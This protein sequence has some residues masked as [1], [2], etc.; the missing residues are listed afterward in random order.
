MDAD[1]GGF[2]AGASAGSEHGDV[3]AGRTA[4]TVCAPFFCY[5]AAPMALVNSTISMRLPPATTTM[6]RIVLLVNV[7]AHKIASDWG[8]PQLPK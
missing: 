6:A 7:D 8:F 1:A 2:V 5:G 3:D 4:G